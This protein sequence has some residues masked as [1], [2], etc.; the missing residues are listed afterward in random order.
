M[1]QPDYSAVLTLLQRQFDRNESVST[2]F[3][4][5][6]LLM[7]ISGKEKPGDGLDKMKVERLMGPDFE[8]PVRKMQSVT[9]SAF[10]PGGSSDTAD[11]QENDPTGVARAYFGYFKTPLRINMIQLQEA[12]GRNNAV[13]FLKD[14]VSAA[15]EGAKVKVATDIFRGTGNGAQGTL[16][17]G[18][19]GPATS[20]ANELYGLIYQMRAYSGT[21]NANA[22]SN[23]NNTHFGLQRAT[24][25][26]FVCNVAD[27]G[28]VDDGAG[29]T[30]VTLEDVTLTADSTVISGAASAAYAGYL[31]WR[32]FWKETTEAASA[33]RP[34]SASTL[35][36]PRGYTV[37]DTAA[38]AAT[39]FQMSQTWHGATGTYDVQLR[40]W[41]RSDIHGA[42]GV[43]SVKKLKFMNAAVGG[44]ID[45]ALASSALVDMF[46]SSLMDNE[47]QVRDAN[48]PILGSQR[49]AA[50]G[51][52]YTMV[53]KTILCIDNYVPSGQV[54]G[55]D[56]RY[57]KP[58]LHKLFDK[59]KLTDDDFQPLT[60]GQRVMSK[61]AVMVTALQIPL[62]DLSRMYRITGFVE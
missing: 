10:Y 38:G 7:A 4:E 26:N 36:A 43:P 24:Q 44:G 53:G 27:C 23:A 8:I 25:P 59:M 22:N 1:S 49:A 52:E 15:L 2:A 12:A 60:D 46:T 50:W 37:A 39:T 14:R 35:G 16:T 48:A 51:Y 29:T 32:I 47:R 58:K 11:Y 33:Y 31:N 3:E 6:P 61:G 18:G 54:F 21:V 57:I 17:T 40:P 5:S 41:F 45:I 34:I 42:A 9:T 20:T 55:F 19:D 56:T 28:S 30:F 13:P 62:V